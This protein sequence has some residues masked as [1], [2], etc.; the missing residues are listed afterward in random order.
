MKAYTEAMVVK[1][2]AIYINGFEVYYQTPSGSAAPAGF[3]FIC[4]Y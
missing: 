1:E 3:S 2:V 4:V